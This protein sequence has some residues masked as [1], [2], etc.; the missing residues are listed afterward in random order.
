MSALGRDI[1]RRKLERNLGRSLDEPMI[2]A[3][4]AI[5]A[6]QAGGKPPYQLLPDFPREAIGAELGS[7][8]YIPP[9][10]MET[11]VNELLATRKR[12]GLGTGQTRVLRHDR[13]AV[14]QLLLSNLIDLENAEDGLYL[15]KHDV[16]YEM[17]RIAQRQFHWQR[18]VANAPNLYRSMFL[19]GSGSAAEFFAEDAGISVAQ[20]VKVGAYFSGAFTR[21]A[22]ID[23]DRDLSELGITLEQRNAALARFSLEIATAR[24][25]AAA[26]RAGRRHTAYRPSLLRG[27]P[28]LAFGPDGER[29]I[30]PIP[31]LVMYRY[32]SG[33]YLDVVR[34]GAGVWTD[35]GRRF[36]QYVHDYLTAM[37]AP[38]HVSRETTYGPKKASFRTPDVLISA[39]GGTVV[40][41]IECKAKRMTFEARFGDDPVLEA[42]MGFDEMAKGI[43]QLWRFFAHAR[44]GIAGTPSV[45]P[46]C[47]GILVTADSW[48]A[49]ALKQAVDVLQAANAL[50]DAEGSIEPEDRRDI[51]FCQ[52]DDVEFAL[53]NG[54]GT[55]FLDGCR[56][57]AS[58][59][60]KGWM[61]LVAHAAQKDV[62]RSYPF[63]DR[64]GEL[65]PWFAAGK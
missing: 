36:E 27:Y 35:I 19:Y 31:E 63:T 64:L 62:V 10:S 34:G 38:Y 3:M 26:M 59:E 50:A 53:Q 29:L 46:D 5:S 8:Y 24:K 42:S 17:A 48:L 30:A 11:L 47:Q 1:Y 49:M 32:T 61:L 54:S 13:F 7:P 41:A 14:F 22:V 2:A 15:Q 52:I 37:M 56:E 9:W 12:P 60:K 39:E 45:A 28:I 6:Y 23:R 44:I 58:G 20:L 51:A 25:S 18:G 55:S 65:L 4:S 57:I 43:Y 21:G 40:A 16:L 33:L